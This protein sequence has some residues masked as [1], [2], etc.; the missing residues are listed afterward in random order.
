MDIK[1]IVLCI[2]AVVNHCV[3]LYIILKREGNRLW[4]LM[5][6]VSTLI[7]TNIGLTLVSEVF[8]LGV[9]SGYVVL[10]QELFWLTALLGLG[11]VINKLGVNQGKVRYWA[12]MT[13][14]TLLSGVGGSLIIYNWLS[15]P[16]QLSSFLLNGI[17]LM[18]TGIVTFESIK[19]VKSEQSKTGRFKGIIVALGIWLMV[20]CVYLAKI[21]AENMGIVSLSVF[22]FLSC[23]S[24]IL[25]SFIFISLYFFGF[26]DFKYPSEFLFN[27][28]NDKVFIL[29]TEGNI[30]LANKQAKKWCKKN[31]I[32]NK[33][34][35]IRQV[36]NSVQYDTA[37]VYKN[38]PF[39]I[40]HKG[41]S[42]MA[43][44][45]QAPVEYFNYIKG[46][47]IIVNES[48]INLLQK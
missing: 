2:A 5:L 47:V 24:I 48:N 44:I 18:I 19:K 7:G 35:H 1:L 22:D 17:Y 31:N 41:Q 6:I 33:L 40:K 45:S 39:Y 3:F 36:I 16:T 15:A 9:L 27:E 4:L 34:K 12:V 46:K 30:I 14:L 13:N 10:I 23:M 8:S 37:K 38:S 32:D 43:Y 28:V 11:L 42:K 26:L 21:V 20:G 25:N 29:D